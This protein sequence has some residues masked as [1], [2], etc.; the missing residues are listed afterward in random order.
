MLSFEAF[1]KRC[2][3]AIKED[4]PFI[5]YH[6]ANGHFFLYYERAIDVW[7]KRARAWKPKLHKA[8]K[9][10]VAAWRKEVIKMQKDPHVVGLSVVDFDRDT[11]TIYGGEELN[12]LYAVYLS[13]RCDSVDN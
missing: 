11:L 13:S 1:F 12:A 9:A 4:A 10:T 7:D 2:E 3:A 8:K 6:H 5:A